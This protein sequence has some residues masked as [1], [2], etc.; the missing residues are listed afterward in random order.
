MTSAMRKQNLGAI[1]GAPPA[2][3]GKPTKGFQPQNLGAF[4]KIGV[5]F[6]CQ[7]HYVLQR[8]LVPS[9]LHFF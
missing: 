2:I 3:G 7:T 1:L 9:R 4:L 8:Q 6:A 5:V